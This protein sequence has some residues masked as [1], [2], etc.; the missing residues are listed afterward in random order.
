MNRITLPKDLRMEKTPWMHYKIRKPK[1]VHLAYF[2]I[3]GLEV[4]KICKR[5]EVL[6][7][8][9][10]AASSFLPHTRQELKGASFKPRTLIA[11]VFSLF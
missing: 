1:E 8:F 10:P 5:R 9:V 7:L 4:V 6:Y 3:H 11:G 2:S